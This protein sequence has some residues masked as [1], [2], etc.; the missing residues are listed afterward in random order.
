MV[1]LGGG[2]GQGRC[3]QRIEVIVKCKKK[4]GRGS[5][6]EGVWS[7]GGGPVGCGGQSGCVRRIEAIV[8]MPKKSE[9]WS[10]E[11]VVG[12]GGRLV[13][14]LGVVGDVGDV[15]HWGRRYC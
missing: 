1:R 6:R 5:G 8:K 10:G 7:V 11:G 12:G 3:V 14:R 2:G 13:A 15:G 9:V 4:V